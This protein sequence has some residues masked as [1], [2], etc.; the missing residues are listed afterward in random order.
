MENKGKENLYAL[1]L[2]KISNMSKLQIII[3]MI[4][5]GICFL[6]AIL[7]LF[8]IIFKSEIQL[9]WENI[10]YILWW[11][12]FSW[13]V[14]VILPLYFWKIDSE[15]QEKIIKE[16]LKKEELKEEIL[17]VVNI[18]KDLQEKFK[19]IDF[20]EFCDINNEVKFWKDIFKIKNNPKIT[21][22]CAI[23]EEI[24]NIHNFYIR[25]SSKEIRDKILNYKNIDKEYNKKL[26]YN[27]TH[28][29]Y[30]ETEEMCKDWKYK[31]AIDFL[32]DILKKSKV[33]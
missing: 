31:E 17:D 4:F 12:F 20:L 26:W 10:V 32:I 8:Y 25:S 9:T 3:S 1:A 24:W 11:L 30:K 23:D 14:L 16:E 21:I 6:I 22:V 27:F 2:D 13:L 7:L 5:W 15:I 19:K 28:L 18:L 29:V 33:I